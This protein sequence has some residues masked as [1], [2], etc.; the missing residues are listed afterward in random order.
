MNDL[1][2]KLIHGV[3][4]T[5]TQQSGQ[6]VLSLLTLLWLAALLGPDAF[7]L[8]AL[9]TTFNA[10]ISVCFGEGIRESLVQRQA[11]DESHFSSAF[12]C[13]LLLASVLVAVAVLSAPLVERLFR[14][15]GLTEIVR[16]L[17]LRLV[18]T[19]VLSVPL[20]RLQRQMAYKK[21]AIRG[22]I[23]TAA[24]A[25]T[26]VVMALNGYGVWSLVGK[27][28]VQSSV[29]AIGM[30]TASGWRPHMMIS[31]PVLR[32]LLRFEVSLA[33]NNVV[34]FLKNRL[35]ILLIGLSFSPSVLGYYE[36]ANT[37][38]VGLGNILTVT[39]SSVAFAGFSRLQDDRERLAGLYLAATRISASVAMPV[40]FGLAI[41]APLAA[42]VLLSEKWQPVAPVL[43]ALCVLGAIR[44]VQFFQGTVLRAVGEPRT[45]F[46]NN[47]RHGVLCLLVLTFAVAMK[48]GVR[49]VA[50]LQVVCALAIQPLW[51]RAV[52]RSIGVGFGQLVQQMRVPIV[53]SLLMLGAV[54]LLQAT[55]DQLS[56]TWKL[57]DSILIGAATYVGA[58]V[59]LSPRFVS[60]LRE[61]AT[62]LLVAKRR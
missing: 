59:I 23:G 58:T 25:V 7:G 31:S 37:I 53:A 18:A 49:D 10:M 52:H 19:A 42:E 60:D 57:I 2:H 16:A 14:A 15:D 4:W 22:L 24:G 29:R 61:M 51:I 46:R 47:A 56:A 6:Q 26:A 3:M 28:L 17:S 35:A 43:S 13:N 34:I 5:V 1:R 38:M 41:T 36:L 54:F 32:E 55:A 48:A 30:W 20:A 33:G 50:I 39:M 21:I 40:F 27:E 62:Q 8:L 45:T 44:S 9:A 12:W 11:C